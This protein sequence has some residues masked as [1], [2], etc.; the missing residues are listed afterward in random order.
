MGQ[1]TV[2]QYNSHDFSLYSDTVHE[3]PFMVDL[4]ATFQHESGETVENLPGFYNGDGEW[5]VRFSPTRTGRWTGRTTST[6]STLSRVELDEVICVKNDNPNIHGRLQIDPNQPQRFA[7]EDGTPFVMLGFESDWLF[8]YHQAAPKRCR[9]HVELIH[10]RGFNDIVMNIY[11]HTG[12]SASGSRF[13]GVVIPGTIYSPPQHY[14]FGGDNDNPDHSALN[15]D[16]FKDYDQLIQMLHEKGIVAHL[17][18]QVQNKHVNW[19]KRYSPEDNLYWRYVVTRYQ[20][21]GNVVW[22]VGKES[23]NLVREAGSHNYILDRI[24]LI[25]QSDAYNHLVTVHDSEGGSMARYSE[26]D[27]ASDFCSDQ[28]HLSDVDAYNRE[29]ICRLRVRSKP[30]LNIEYGY[31]LGAEDLKTYRSRTTAPWQDVLK[32]T[33][34]LYLAGAYPCYYYSNT[35]WDL[36]KFEP[37]PEGWRRYQ[38]LKA[39]LGEIPFNEMT[40]M[41]D[42]VDN[43]YC[44]AKP[45]EVYLVYLPEG[46]NTQL[47]LTELPYSKDEVGRL[48]SA[49]VTVVGEWMDIYSGAR[50]SAAVTPSGWNTLIENPFEDRSSPCVLV[51][52]VV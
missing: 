30:Y 3:N 42:L 35:S 41:N 7:W 9:E 52:N 14:V 6:D 28:I 15:I 40:A 20:A 21:Y 13:D 37:E 23:R 26:S 19:P 38:Y 17:M 4:S 11:A 16:F 51:V 43:G 47:D 39:L 24:N 8:S 32:W 22:D 44:L 46:G 29:A 36:I 27:D 10:S 50:L 18:I 12:F 2:A 33:Y 45:G 5:V 34:A 48:E 49:E 25:R 1:I 31:E